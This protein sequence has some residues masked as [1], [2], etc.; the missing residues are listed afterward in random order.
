LPRLDADIQSETVRRIGRLEEVDSATAAEVA[1]HL[2][3]RVAELQRESNNPAQR[4]LKAIIDAMPREQ[5]ASPPADTAPV[6]S[7]VTTLTRPDS[8]S[9]AE[10]PAC[11]QRE[12]ESLSTEDVHLHLIQLPP[13]ALC[14]ALGQVSTREALLTL[15]GLP[16]QVAETALAR[17]PRGRARQVRRGMAN[18]R[19]IRLREIDEAKEAVALASLASLAPDFA[20]RVAPP[21]AA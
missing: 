4:T 3:Q 11:P 21:Q 14:K 17:L 9:A 13:R 12:R 10:T 20:T 18:L 19:S 6:D 5:E 16:N 7:G 8:P 1:A 2:Q 15:C